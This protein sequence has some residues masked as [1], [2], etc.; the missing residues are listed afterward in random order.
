MEK[1]ETQ[2]GYWTLEVLCYDERKNTHLLLNVISNKK[3]IIV[4]ILFYN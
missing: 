3:Y 2:G 1:F 4:V